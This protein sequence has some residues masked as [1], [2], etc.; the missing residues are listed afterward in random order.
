MAAAGFLSSYVSGPL[1]YVWRHI[2]DGAV[3]ESSANGGG[4]RGRYWVHISVPAPTQ[5]E[6]LKAQ[7]VGIRPLRPLLSH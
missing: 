2:T 5:S 6:F 4:G 7:W 1:P 3:A